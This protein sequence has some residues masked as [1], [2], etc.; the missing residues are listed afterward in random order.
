MDRAPRY[1][2]KDYAE[3]VEFPVE[4]VARDGVV[5]RYP[6]DEAVYLYFRRSRLAAARL[7]DV[8]LVRAEVAHCA[9]RIDQLRQSYFHQHGW[10][11]QPGEDPADRLGGLRGELAFF[12]QRLVS[13][14]VWREFSFSSRD[15]GSDGCGVWRIHLGDKELWLDVARID[16][17]SG[18]ASRER[19]R[20]LESR[21]DRQLLASHQGFD[22]VFLLTSVDD[23]TAPDLSEPQGGIDG[24]EEAL[25]EAASGPWQRVV[26]ATTA[27]IQRYPWHRRA[28]AVGAASAL[29]GGHAVEALT[30]AEAGLRRCPA[31]PALML[32][33]GLARMDVGDVAEGLPMLRAAL[34][35]HPSE[36][37][38]DE[39]LLAA[40]WWAARPSWIAEC[41]RDRPR[42]WRRRA[43]VSA[44]AWRGAL[45]C[46]LAL[47][48]VA[49]ATGGWWVGAV[50]FLGA[51][52]AEAGRRMVARARWRSALRGLGLS[53][54]I[55]VLRRFGRGRD[56]ARNAC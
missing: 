54:P 30:L 16:P 34:R 46:G 7:A 55:R 52:A 11:A 13:E 20:I 56:A 27:L 47:G 5:R 26:A 31:D 37:D 1:D 50:L 9:S 6:Y 41:L 2:R 51:L 24:W 3:R 39:V 49:F 21:G 4:I 18:A 45:A 15:V 42:G 48:L 44:L 8:G 32:I 12:L 29:G 14:G 38:L 35:R 43:A 36:P 28:W 22:C 19:R 10:P 17:E 25:V 23:G 33:V 53:E 40:E